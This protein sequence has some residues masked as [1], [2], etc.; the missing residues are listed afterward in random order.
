[1]GD[2]IIMHK[3]VVRGRKIPAIMISLLAITIALYVVEITE[4]M[5]GKTF[6]IYR[7]IDIILLIMIVFVLFKEFKY[8]SL[9]YKYSIIADKLIINKLNS[10]GDNILESIR[11]QDIVFI[12][13]RIE[14]PKNISKT[15]SRG[16]YLSSITTTKRYYCI[17]EKD[18]QL[19]KFSFEP[20]ERLLKRIYDKVNIKKCEAN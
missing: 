20:S 19:M 10:K 4:I 8:C 3:E 17:Y 2:L 12:G 13:K 15:K 9:A 1:M 14:I 7:V 5:I 11:I 6:Q 18:G 16:N